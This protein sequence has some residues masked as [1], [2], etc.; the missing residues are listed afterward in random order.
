[1]N[2]REE[3]E[4]AKA[5]LITAL[6]VI[7]NVATLNK[8]RVSKVIKA[9][10][11][12]YAQ[13]GN[14]SVSR[15]LA[16]AAEQIGLDEE[17]GIMSPLVHEPQEAFDILEDNPNTEA[18]TSEA[19]AYLVLSQD[20]E[21]QIFEQKRATSFNR[22]PRLESFTR[23]SLGMAKPVSLEF[24]KFAGRRGATEKEGFKRIALVRYQFPGV[25]RS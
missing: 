11:K 16:Y 25:R 20:C 12:I 15:H 13:S 18:E 6:R 24:Y 4:Q 22:L 23:T 17:F 19:E 8:I 3:R 14:P 5:T 7:L 21:E 1:M 9:L 10:A 2:K